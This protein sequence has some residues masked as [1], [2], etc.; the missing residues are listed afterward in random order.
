MNN[1]IQYNVQKH[2]LFLYNRQ[3]IIGNAQYITS[4]MSASCAFH[5]ATDNP[6][7]R[8]SVDSTPDV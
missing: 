6:V 8:S 4:T 1:V 2:G 5:D 7:R 3:N